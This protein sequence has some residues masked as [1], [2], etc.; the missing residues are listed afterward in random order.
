VF[1]WSINVGNILTII[2]L[3]AAAISVVVSMKSTLA[4]FAERLRDVENEI[5]KLLGVLIMQGKVEERLKF[6]DERNLAQGKRLDST[7]ERLS[8]HLD[9][10]RR[11]GS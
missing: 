2:G 9:E 7:E 10:A 1:D 4:S 3:V 5:E 11:G 6:I 8:R